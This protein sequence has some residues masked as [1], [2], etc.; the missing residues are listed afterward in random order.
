MRKSD[1]QSISAGDDSTNVIAGR[2]I[3]IIQSGV[4]TELVDQKIDDEVERLRR[5]RFFPEYDRTRTAASLGKQL[6]RGGALSGGSGKT[7]RRGLAWCA[8]VLA[9]SG[10]LAR[11]AGLLELARDL[12]DSPE[13]QIA[14]AFIVS[15]GG[16]KA[17]ALRIL[18]AIDSH[19]S[20]SAALMIVAHH[21]GADAALQWMNDTG[22]TA[23]HLDSDGKRL[24]L[25][26]QLELGNWGDANDTVGALSETDFTES[27]SLR[28]LRP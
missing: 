24:L 18:A 12:G 7:R 9:P 27:P 5:S 4:P 21:D 1:K 22:R 11:A 14:E 19:S 23:D 16:N 13:A 8:R 20:R 10:D 15:Q 25:A 28:I 2:D 17:E 6:E 26:N 3:N